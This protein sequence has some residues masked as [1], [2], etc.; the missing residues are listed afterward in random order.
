MDQ[1]FLERGG[2]RLF[3]AH[4]AEHVRRSEQRDECD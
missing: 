2:Q 4:V 1:A 3:Y